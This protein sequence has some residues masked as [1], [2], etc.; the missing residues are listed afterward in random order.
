MQRGRGGACAAPWKGV[1]VPPWRPR[2]SGP[3]PGATSPAP[4]CGSWRSRPARR[5]PRAD[6]PWSAWTW[7]PWTS[8]PSPSRA[9]RLPWIR[10][11]WS[12]AW[13][14]RIGP[15]SI[16]FSGRA[17]CRTWRGSSRT[18]CG[19]TC[20]RSCPPCPPSCGRRSPPGWNRTGTASWTSW[21]AIPGRGRSSRSP[22]SSVG[23]RRYGRCCRR[24]ACRWGWW[25]GGRPGPPTPC[26]VT[27]SRTASPTSC[28]G[29]GRTSRTHAARRGPRACTVACVPA[30][31]PR[32]PS[33]GRTSAPSSRARATSR[34][35]S[36]PTSDSSSTNSAP[37][38]PRPAPTWELPWPAG[39]RCTP[40]WRWSISREPTRPPTSS[41]A[42]ARRPSRGF[43]G[44][45]K[46]PSARSS[47]AC[48][49]RRIAGWGTWWRAWT[50]P[51]R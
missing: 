24:Q 10:S 41:C 33:P 20:R 46:P 11:S 9:P 42:T 16:R 34:S 40:V 35:S 13:T 47:I 43:P 51:G 31:W 38:S 2:I 15:F 7:P 1:C 12:S 44:E 28:S 19:R 5:W 49:R 39:N 21:S 36:P 23:R 45:G 14:G 4:C 48:T 27:S 37:C 25:V 29:T 18:A 3:R 8:Y 50:A 22:R 30:S 17:A 6:S 26:A 32:T